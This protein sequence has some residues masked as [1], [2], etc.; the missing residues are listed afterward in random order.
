[1]SRIVESLYGKYGLNEKVNIDNDDIIET[2]LLWSVYKDELEAGIK[3]LE[4]KGIK[5]LNV[6]QPDEDWFEFEIDIQGKK[7]IICDELIKEYGSKEDAEEFYPELFDDYLN[8]A[9]NPE[10]DE[11]NAILKNKIGKAKLTKKEQEIL[12]KYGITRDED[13]DWVGPNGKRMWKRSGKSVYGPTAPGKYHKSRSWELGNQ[14]GY[15]KNPQHKDSYDE[16]DFANYLTKEPTDFNY[17]QPYRGR[18]VNNE[19]YETPDMGK[20][21]RPY[22]D[23]YKIAKRDRDYNQRWADDKNV[24]SDDEIEKE[25]DRYRKT[26]KKYQQRD[27]RAKDELQGKADEKQKEIDD[28]I[29]RAKEK[30]QKNE[31]LNEAAVNINSRDDYYNYIWNSLY[32]TIKNDIL[33]TLSHKEVDSKY[34]ERFLD[35]VAE[36]LTDMF[37]E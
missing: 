6:D 21:N 24:M 3:E 34:L 4:Q 25:T 15:P 14:G 7:S 27:Q 29:A 22:S 28:I 11:V 31:S 5:V 19:P 37:Y 8:E 2:T 23:D 18:A 20:A 26:L 36:D 32:S 12:D 30:H 13:G 35:D 9:R 16:V 33:Q 10:N 1:M 17:S